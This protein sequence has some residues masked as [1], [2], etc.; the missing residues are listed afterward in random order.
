MILRDSKG[1]GILEAS[2]VEHEK[3]DSE[4]IELIAMLRALQ[5][6]MTWGIP[7]LMM[8]SDCLLMLQE[9]KKAETSISPVGNVQKEVQRFMMGF[10]KCEVRHIHR[11]GNEVAHRLACLES[12]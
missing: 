6:C 8:E 1:D 7:H 10:V 9:L 11:L 12:R 5:L 2:K 3:A 4:P